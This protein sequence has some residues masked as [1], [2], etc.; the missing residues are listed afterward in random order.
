MKRQGFL[1]AIALLTTPSV[2]EAKTINHAHQYE[3]CMTL[4]REAPDEAFDAGL[5]WKSYG[6][7]EAAEHCIATALINM[8]R[9]ATGAD[10]LEKLADISR[11]PKEFKAQ[12][13]AQAAQGWFLAN[14]VDRARAVLTT[15]I[16]LDGTV[17]DFY[18]DRAQMRSAQNAFDDALRDLDKALA[19]DDLNVDAL[20]FRGTIY[21]LT[22]K[23]DQAMSDIKK[24]VALDP[25]HPEALLERGMLYR[26]EGSDE[27]A[28]TD[29][30]DVIGIDP[31]SDTAETAR[32]NLQRMEVT[33]KSE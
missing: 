24:A 19:L 2:L 4:V 23:F 20:I 33:P 22:E 26:I 8:K 32:L 5:A 21:R 29:W 11:K 16:D 7:G 17:A 3:A 6:G 27:K 12:I 28:R 9:Y 14:E 15:A 31:L 10:R 25:S 18:V 30:L 1:V 13:L